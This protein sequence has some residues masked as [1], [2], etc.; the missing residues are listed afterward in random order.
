MLTECRIHRD[1]KP[2]S[3][4]S[5]LYDNSVG[6]Y[7]AQQRKCSKRAMCAE[8][9]KKKKSFHLY[10]EDSVFVLLAQMDVSGEP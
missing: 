10:L 5:I 3:L 8:S 2:S 6:L 4:Y 1:N 7:I 9:K